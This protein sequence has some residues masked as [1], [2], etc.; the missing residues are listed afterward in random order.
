[1]KMIL[2]KV[3]LYFYRFNVGFIYVLFWPLLYCFSRKPGRY[4]YMNKMRSAWGYLSSLFSGFIYRF[5]YEAPIDWSRTYII[6]PNH[7]SNLDIS[8]ISVLTKNSYS[9]MGKDDLLD[10]FVTGIFFRSV[11]IPV[12]RE[13]K[14]SSFK[15]FKKAGDRLESGI[16]MIIFPEGTIPDHYPPKLTAFKNGP[17]RL[18]IELKIPIIPVTSLD[19]W[20]YLWD[21]GDEYGSK[22]GVCNIFVHAPIETAH[23]SIDDTEELKN[24]VHGIINQKFEHNDHR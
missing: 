5:E 6:C 7:I 10:G 21:T 14:M 1:M 20:K 18:A 24:R 13:S 2:K 17:F 4:K 19:T 16:S 11:D 22:P 9:F 3:H 15:A 23:L 12:N 8:A